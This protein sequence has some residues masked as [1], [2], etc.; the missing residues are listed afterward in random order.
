MCH[1]Q[2][3]WC[4]DE[5]TGRLP[6][7]G[8]GEEHDSG[9]HSHWQALLVD[10]GIRKDGIESIMIVRDILRKEPENIAVDD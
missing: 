2:I 10:E 9:Y 1:L 8:N 4:R 3:P 5:V 7:P 6:G